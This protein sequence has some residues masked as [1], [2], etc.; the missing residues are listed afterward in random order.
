M[1]ILFGATELEFQ[2]QLESSAFLDET[3]VIPV[4]DSLT[5]SAT[6]S[7]LSPSPQVFVPHKLPPIKTLD[8]RVGSVCVCVCVCVCVL[9]L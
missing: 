6:F 4:S 5:A 8:I 3:W 9:D 7:P 1:A 2:L